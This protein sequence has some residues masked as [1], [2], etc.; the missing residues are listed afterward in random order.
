MFVRR[1]A[2]DDGP[3]SA[4]IGFQVPRYTAFERPIGE[5]SII[6]ICITTSVAILVDVTATATPDTPTNGE[7]S[8]H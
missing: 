4:G 7:F 5:D 6:S 2:D 8:N 1:F 3:V